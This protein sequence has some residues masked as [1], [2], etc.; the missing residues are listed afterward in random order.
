[1]KTC[2]N[3]CYHHKLV[4]CRAMHWN[5]TAWRL[6]SEHRPYVILGGRGNGL[7][8]WSAVYNCFGRRSRATAFLLW[9]FL[10]LC[11]SS[12]A[13]I[14]IRPLLT[15][16]TLSSQAVALLAYCTG[17][18][19]SASSPFAMACMYVCAMSRPM[20]HSPRL[21]KWMLCQPTHAPKISVKSTGYISLS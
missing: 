12:R 21:V 20:S 1:M 9:S 14:Y 18:D 4:P 17:Q 5:P 16:V 11:V 6:I 3:I 15:V 8:E 10:T 2:K 13:L 7:R 19:C